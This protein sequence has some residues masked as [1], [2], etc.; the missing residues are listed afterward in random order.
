MAEKLE[1]LVFSR[2]SA[3]NRDWRGRDCA[4]LG[5][6]LWTGDIMKKFVG[7][8]ILALSLAGC[9][10]GEQASQSDGGSWWSW[11][12]PNAWF[13]TAGPAP[14]APR[15]V[16]GN[17]VPANRLP[18]EP[19]SRGQGLPSDNANA[20][21]AGDVRGS[22]RGTVG[23]APSANVPS[24]PQPNSSASDAVATQSL[25]SPTQLDGFGQPDSDPLV[26]EGDK[27][28]ADFP[29]PQFDSDLNADPNRVVL[30]PPVSDKAIPGA[31]PSGSFD[32]SF[33][34]IAG[35]S[36]DS[37][38]QRRSVRVAQPSP[39][40]MA[41]QQ[42]AASASRW[43]ELRF[44]GQQA[45]Q[46][47]YQPQQ[48]VLYTRPQPQVPQ[49]V[50]VA[51]QPVQPVQPVAQQPAAV[52]GQGTSIMFGSGSV[53]LSQQDRKAILRAAIAQKELGGRIRVIGHA[54][55]PGSDAAGGKSGFALSLERANKV[56]VAL[57]DAGV[58][59]SAIL[60]EARGVT[61]RRA[62]DLIVE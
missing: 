34:Q 21:Y 28:A 18:N 2:Q 37:G 36:I 61:G 40:P 31:G 23:D 35:R 57:M 22:S 6:K 9:G 51:P 14:D 25:Q 3:P 62:A 17:A 44:D 20:Q 42:V 50:Y 10:G 16:E 54:D 60:V 27:L 5:R 26:A 15:Q 7:V 11:A 1:K 56:A 19:M 45:A 55:N 13:E 49:Q 48:Q 41:P 12:D 8:S 33:E 32:T 38:T 46:P 4:D 59:N 29:A 53:G 39:V 58:P 30:R 24:F 47:A 52:S 43:G